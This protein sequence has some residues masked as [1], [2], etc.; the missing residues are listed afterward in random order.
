MGWNDIRFSFFEA[1]EFTQTQAETALDMETL[2]RL[3]VKTDGWIAGLLLI[4]RRLK[5]SS[6]DYNVLDSLSFDEV[7][8]Y[9]SDEIFNKSEQDTRSFLLKTAFM[10]GI[11]ASMAEQLTGMKS[12]ERFL[13]RLAR[14]NFFTEK[15]SYANPVYQYHPLFREFLLARA[16]K[17]FTPDELGKIRRKAA[18]LL[19]EAGRTE[20]AAGLFIEAADWE[21]LA[22]LIVKTAEALTSEGRYKTLGEWLG[23]IPDEFLNKRS[24]L[25]YWKG[26]YLLPANPAEARKSFEAAYVLFKDEDDKLG[27]FLTWS[28]IVDTFMYE[29]KDFHP[30][31][32]WIRELELLI[33]R[34]KG[35]GSK[36]VEDLITC[37]MFCALMFRQPQHPDLPRW[38]EKAEQVMNHSSDKAQSLFIGY[39]L[40]IYN[41]WIGQSCRCRSHCRFIV[42]PVSPG[43][44]AFPVSSGVVKGRGLI[45]HLCSFL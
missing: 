10:P 14:N 45:L 2:T 30:L 15:H 39:N 37:R 12:S 42:S 20:D 8:T 32:H 13:S 7:F 11:T 25:L 31:D 29:W 21:N 36:Q 24:W 5:D 3:F 6:I 44:P 9:F 18:A 33:R 17:T 38:K 35:F 28:F 19:E 16:I 4:M 23:R 34:Y 27:L 41:I 26:A 43:K 1:R 22:D 40:V